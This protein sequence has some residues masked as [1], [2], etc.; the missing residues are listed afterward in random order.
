M[1]ARFSPATAGFALAIVGLPL[2]AV[3]TRDGSAQTRAGVVTMPGDDTASFAR[4][5]N[6]VRGVSPMLCELAIR[7]VD[8]RHGWWNGSGSD[9]LEVDSTAAALIDWAHRKH[10]DPTV[11]PRLAAWLRDS[12]ACVRRIAGSFLA[13]VDHP[14]AEAVLLAAL[15]EANA[16]TRLSAVIG[17]GLSEKSSRVI[18]PLLRRLR[19]DSPLVRRSAAWALGEHEATE[20]MSP[21]IE[22]LGRDPDPRVRQAAARALGE[23]SK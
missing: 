13:R 10:T 21:L 6:T 14:S 12:D 2:T 7:S 5:M 16:D 20:A 9:P 8:G 23:I 1:R 22:L 17:L 11:V 4:F 19:D 18:E 15:G 3:C